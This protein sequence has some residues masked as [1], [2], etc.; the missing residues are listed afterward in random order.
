MPAGCWFC[1]KKLRRH[2][3]KCFWHMKFT[4]N[5]L[6]GGSRHYTW[7]YSR[8]KL[9]FSLKIMKTGCILFLA[10]RWF[11][12]KKLRR[13]D[14]KY[15][16]TYEIYD[17]YHLRGFPSLHM[18]LFKVKVDIFIKNHENKPYSITCWMLISSEKAAASWYKIFLDIWNLR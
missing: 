8:S 13:H 11:R 14:T 16:W 18:R 5:T 12:Q 17:K 6:W 9:K 1:Q 15:S 4:I 7:G 10:V 2:G 3:T